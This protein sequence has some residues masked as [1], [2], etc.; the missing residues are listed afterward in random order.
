[1]NENINADTLIY[2]ASKGH[3]FCTSNIAEYLRDH[4]ILDTI[5]IV[6][7]SEFGLADQDHLLITTLDSVNNNFLALA[8]DSVNFFNNPDKYSLWKDDGGGFSYESEIT[9][10]THTGVTALTRQTGVYLNKHGKEELIKKL[11]PYFHKSEII[12]VSNEVSLVDEC[13]YSTMRLKFATK[14]DHFDV[15]KEINTTIVE[16]TGNHNL[17]Y[18]KQAYL[19]TLNWYE[20][21]N[22]SYFGGGRSPAEANKPLLKRLK[23]SSLVA[24]IGFNEYCPLRE[25]ADVNM[26]AN[27]YNYTKAKKLIDSLKND[28]H[29]DFIV[30]CVQ[31]RETDSYTPT[32]S[33]TSICN[34]LIDMGADI[35]FG[36]QAHQ[37][38]E[39]AI[40]KRKPIFYGLGNFLFDQIHRIGVRQAFFLECY[41]YKGKIIQ[42]QP[43]YT[44]MGKNRQP[45][46]ATAT[47]KRSIQN[48]ILKKH[49]FD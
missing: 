49:N 14:K 6:A 8:Y 26:G 27:R 16:L 43:V 19:N 39:I 20:Q 2:L 9:K 21:N 33:Q 29:T 31:F 44:Y 46:I 28:L 42:C 45:N 12:H 24:W 7:M 13:D 35:I 32:T 4:L 48:A 40:Y 25:C 34:D 30:A 23:D 15:L 10:Y 17:D 3:V 18:G 11:L 1:M 38:Q 36:S 37:A 47:E 22:M 5:P 41:F